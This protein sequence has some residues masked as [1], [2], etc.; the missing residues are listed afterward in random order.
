M[1]EVTRFSGTPLVL[2]ADLIEAVEASP[3]TNILLANGRRYV[4]KNSVPE[5]LELT[6]AW[7][8]RCFQPPLAGEKAIERRHLE[9]RSQQEK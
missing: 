8:R 1:I 5:I 6:A 7:K 9:E 3:D 2:N 4:V